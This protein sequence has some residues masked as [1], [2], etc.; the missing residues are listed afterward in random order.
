MLFIIRLV[1]CLLFWENP[2]FC[3]N[4]IDISD[5]VDPRSVVTNM[6]QAH[7]WHW[8]RSSARLANCWHDLQALAAG[9]SDHES[10]S[11]IT[12]TGTRLVLHNTATTW[13]SRWG[14]FYQREERGETFLCIVCTLH[15]TQQ[16]LTFCPPDSALQ[17]ETTVCCCVLRKPSP[18]FSLCFMNYMSDMKRLLMYACNETGTDMLGVL[19]LII[20]TLHKQ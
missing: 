5:S 17:T 15:F 8:P 16:S 14:S 4:D 18:V 12:E 19:G 1:L 20:I 11:V 7:T 9:Q 6:W 13:S 3:M 10:C 2:L